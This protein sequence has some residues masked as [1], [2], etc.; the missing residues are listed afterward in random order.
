MR[1]AAGTKLYARSSDA[2]RVTAGPRAWGSPGR[3]RPTRRRQTGRTG[4]SS[5]DATGR[6]AIYRDGVAWQTCRSNRPP[7]GPVPPPGLA[8]GMTLSST[9]R[10]QVRRLPGVRPAQEPRTDRRDIQADENPFASFRQQLPDRLRRAQR[11]NAS[12][13][14]TSPTTSPVIRCTC[15]SPTPRARRSLDAATAVGGGGPLPLRG[16]V[17][18]RARSPPSFLATAPERFARPP[19]AAGLGRRPR[20]RT[21]IGTDSLNFLAPAGASLGVTPGR[22]RLTAPNLSA[23]GAGG[24]RGTRVE[25]TSA[26]QPRTTVVPSPAAGFSYLSVLNRTGAGR[27]PAARRLRATATYLNDGIAETD[28][29]LRITNTSKDRPLTFNPPGRRSRRN[30]SRARRPG[31]PREQGDG[32]WRRRQPGRQ[33][34]RAAPR[35]GPVGPR[36]QAPRVDRSGPRPRSPSRP[37]DAVRMSLKGI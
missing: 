19:A 33:D 35:P 23:D 2:S 13:S 21:P 9:V 5:G 31:R 27:G 28:L 15:T 10:G 32:P 26:A 22:S 25:L 34:R 36:A 16:P 30:S 7:T 37:G 17:P 12:G 8:A 14:S 11:P 20:P 18:A 6:L 4:L 1:D 24:S 29:E 3:S